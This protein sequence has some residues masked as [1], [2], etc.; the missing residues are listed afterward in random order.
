MTKVLIDSCGWVAAV[1]GGVNF[2]LAISP[3]VGTFEPVVLPRVR[4]ELQAV[5]DGRAKPLLLDLLDGRSEAVEPPEGMKHTD[6][7]LVAVARESS[8]PVLTVDRGLKQRLADAGCPFIGVV[9]GRN[10]RLIEF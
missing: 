8:W 5:Q 4:K 2:D 10:L 9:S 1:D 7:Q 3:L 6:D